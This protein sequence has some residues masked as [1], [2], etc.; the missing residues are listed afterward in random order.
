MIKNLKDQNIQSMERIQKNQ[1]K[2]STDCSTNGGAPRLAG[3]VV[4]ARFACFVSNPHGGGLRCHSAA[5]LERR[6][7]FDTLG[8]EARAANAVKTMPIAY[9]MASLCRS[10]IATPKW[11]S[12]ARNGSE[13]T[14]HRHRT[15]GARS[16]CVIDL[17]LR[18]LASDM[19]A[20]AVRHRPTIPFVSQ[21]IAALGMLS[22][23]PSHVKQLFSKCNAQTTAGHAS[24]NSASGNCRMSAGV[25]PIQADG[26]H[27][28]ASDQ[29]LT[30]R[31][32]RLDAI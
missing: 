17:L 2:S 30:Y 1:N 11:V 20:P 5:P 13:T 7:L 26:H 12:V 32:V 3:C 21:C 8:C 4:L 22:I 23:S 15:M 31:S 14:K 24:P 25:M 16:I 29:K 6:G 10:L 28:I 27:T 19:K 18:T 9:V